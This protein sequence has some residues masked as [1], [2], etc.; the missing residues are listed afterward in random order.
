MTGQCTRT[1][2]GHHDLVGVGG[3]RRCAGDRRRGGCSGGGTQALAATNPTP[4]ATNRHVALFPGLLMVQEEVGGAWSSGGSGRYRCRQRGRPTGQCARL[5][6][7]R[8]LRS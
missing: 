3:G 8:R 5:E 1:D 6:P 7:R 2:V 4:P